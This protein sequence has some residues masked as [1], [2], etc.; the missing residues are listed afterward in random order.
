MKEDKQNKLQKEENQYKLSKDDQKTINDFLNKNYKN[1]YSESKTNEEFKKNLEKI[2]VDNDVKN[3][4]ENCNKNSN[5][6]WY[7]FW[8]KSGPKMEDFNKFYDDKVNELIKKFEKEKEESRIRELEAYQREIS[9]LNSNISNLSS[10]L[11]Q[12]EN[13]RIKEE[14]NKKQKR[15]EF[16]KKEEEIKNEYF[17]NLENEDFQ[18]NECI[19]K[20]KTYLQIKVKEKKEINNEKTKEKE[21]I[22]ILTNLSKTE[23]FEDK[24]KGEIMIYLKELLNDKTKKVTHL[25]ILLLGKTG[26]GKTTLINTILE[27]ENTDKELKTDNKKPVTMK[28]EYINSDK[29][30][31]L[32]CG[33]SRGIEIGKFGIEAVQEEAEKFIDEQLK[34]NNPDF[35]VHCIWYCT[36][37]ITD[38]FQDDECK[39]LENLGKK[40]SMKELPIIIVGT[41]ANSEQSYMN[42][43]QNIEDNVFKFNY[44][45]VPVIAKKLDDKEVMGLEELKEISI[46]KAK[47]AV[48]SACY[49]GI[50]KKLMQTSKEK[51]KNLEF[52]IK[53]KIQ[54]K[55]KIIIEK[56]EKEGKLNT[57]KEYLKEIFTYILDSYLSIKL[58]CNDEEFIVNKNLYS[59]N[60]EKMITDLINDYFKFCNDI[61]KKSY[62]CIL[63]EKVNTLV[64]KIYNEQISFNIT[65]QNT[66][67]MKTKDIIKQ[68]IKTKIDNILKN[69]ADVYYLKNAFNIFLMFLQKLIPFSFDHFYKTYLEKLEKDNKDMKEMITQKI[70]KQFEELEEKI[71]KYNDEIKEK[72]KKELKEKK[73]KEFEEMKKMIEDEYGMKM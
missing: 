13:R 50:F 45:F 15:K 72:K 51:I 63:K 62:I 35:Y 8:E 65:N 7:Q 9:Y 10:R 26:T 52:I 30:D 56:I 41:K 5:K 14:E 22:E 38:R 6:S 55:A 73:I 36:I 61:S 70:R 59:I 39:L 21:I 47:D 40:Y 54:E 2:T 19:D 58:S 11:N 60:G 68:E 37:P 27:L 24:F 23:K 18:N 17:N 34:I 32:R 53:E 66:I 33:D 43:K 64:E 46:V 20:F 4:K 28:T 31:F 12:M 1:L 29:I 42:L 3:I 67:Q 16:N 69:K 44:P 57:L 71:K 49:Q 25:N 48:E